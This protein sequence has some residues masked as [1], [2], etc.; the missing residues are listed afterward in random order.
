MRATPLTPTGPVALYIRMSTTVTAPDP[1]ATF[2]AQLAASK[3]AA[4]RLLQDLMVS[5]TDPEAPVGAAL[6]EVR[7]VATAILRAKPMKPDDAP[8]PAPTSSPDHPA[9]KPSIDAPPRAA[10]PA[11][12]PRARPCLNP[13]SRRAFT[14]VSHLVQ[15]ANPHIIRE[16]LAQNPHGTLR[17]RRSSEEAAV[18]P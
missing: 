16:L 1:V 14:D 17:P 10:R 9:P 13:T 3:L 6:R 8:P 15:N 5:L 11:A 7:L 18:P 2:N 4:L 12:A